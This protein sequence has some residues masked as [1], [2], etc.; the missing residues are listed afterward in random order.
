MAPKLDIKFIVHFGEYVI[1]NIQG[2][3][4]PMGNSVNLIHR[5]LKNKISE[6]TGWSG[7]ALL[8]K[9]CVTHLSIST[10]QMHTHVEKDENFGDLKTF[11]INLE[12]LYQTYFKS[13]EYIVE[14]KSAHVALTCDFQ[15]P[16]YL[17]W[18]WLNDPQKRREWMTTTATY[19]KERPSGF[20]GPGAVNHCTKSKFNEYIRS[21][22]PFKYFTV[23]NIRGIISITETSH[24]EPTETGT[25]LKWYARMNG[26]LPRWFLEGICRLMVTKILKIEKSWKVMGELMTENRSSLNNVYTEKT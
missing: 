19:E 13:K 1:T 12:E 26:K 6:Q 21:W 24:L 25:H 17:V 8:T 9:E 23:E 15:F 2:R 5:L 16:P 20:L 11:S 14:P 3:K 4:K 22:R 7:Y 18:E 10:K